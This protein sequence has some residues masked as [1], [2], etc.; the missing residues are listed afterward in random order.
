VTEPGPDGNRGEEPGRRG[1]D[2]QKARWQGRGWQG[3][4]RH[5]PAGGVGAVGCMVLGLVLIVG[6]VSTL[7]TWVAAALL[8]VLAPSAAPSTVTAVAVI[9]VIALAILAG[10][11]VFG[12]AV[13]PL[14]EIA[15]ATERLADGEPGVRVRVRGPRPVRGLATSFNTMAE[16]LDRSRDDRRAML[17]DV[18][19]ELRTPI[20]VVQGGLEAMLDGIHPYDEDHVAPL[21][22]ET[23]VMGRL[24]EDLRTLSLADAGALTLH[25]EPADLAAIAREVAAAHKA[26]GEAKGVAV[27]VAGD[28]RLVTS[29]DPVRYREIV[30]NLLAN[31]L[32]HT[33]TGG[34]VEIDV[35]ATA[36]E[37]VL[38]V[39]DTGEGIPADELGRVF[40]RS[41]GRADTGGSGLGLAIVR[42][43][44]EAHG[45]TVTAESE[46]VPGRGASFRVALPLRD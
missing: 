41:Q 11:R 8:G 23:V 4:R 26:V 30:T 5:G 42:D 15:G 45:G 19:H 3:R 38:R 7:A 13:R 37:A 29:V 46:G 28:G 20:T 31:A 25:R 14:G 12:S 18:T 32:R 44:A 16:R 24:L 21:L 40:D 35:R 36:G 39:S 33:P 34:R 10:I 6:L 1:P 17:A 9:V 22:A 27:L 2:W 43:L